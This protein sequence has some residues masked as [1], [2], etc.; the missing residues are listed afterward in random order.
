LRIVVDDTRSVGDN[1]FAEEIEQLIDV[2]RRAVDAWLDY[3]TFTARQGPS[4]LIER[5]V[6]HIGDQVGGTVGVCIGRA[7]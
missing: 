1:A 7:G 4:Q 5:Q 3:T 2:E 6:R